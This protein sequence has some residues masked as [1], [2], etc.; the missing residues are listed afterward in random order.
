MDKNSSRDEILGDIRRGLYGDRARKGEPPPSREEDRDFRAEVEAISNDNIHSDDSMLEQFIDELLNVNAEVRR[1][2]SRDELK[3]SITELVREKEIT[4]FALWESDYLN[5]LGL[6]SLLKEEGSALRKS[7]DKNALAQAEIGITDVD[8]AI[9]DT[10]TLV[11]LTDG[12]RPRG[13]SLLPPIHLAIVRE[14]KLIRNISEL[15]II[16]KQQLDNSSDISSC[17]TFITGPSRTA[18]IELN[19]TLGVHGP[20]ELYVFIVIG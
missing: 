14:D 3:S 18:D 20:K 10:G 17:M 8:Y 15:F 13:V 7:S 1:V 2:N 5:A 6:K 19:L 4:S 9:A 11:L 16:L 12:K